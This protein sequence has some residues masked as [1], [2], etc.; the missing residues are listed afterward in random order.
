MDI[1]RNFKLNLA[2]VAV[3]LLVPSDAALAR[4]DVRILTPTSDSCRS[5]TEAIA[6][7]D[8]PALLALAGWF[9]G[10]LSGVAQ[11]TG[12]DFLRNEDVQDVSERLYDVCMK[13]PDK[14]LSLAAEELARKL[15]ANQQKAH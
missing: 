12:N 4:Q 10:F 13:Q 15:I 2:L 8:K 14:P 7:S 5:Y 6:T 11:G 1:F 9:T 3:A